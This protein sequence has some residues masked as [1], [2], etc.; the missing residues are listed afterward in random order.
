MNNTE[1]D[2]PKNNDTQ[3]NPP[4]LTDE[5]AE[6]YKKQLVDYFSKLNADNP[7]L[8]LNYL[9]NIYN[10]DIPSNERPKKLLMCPHEI[11]ITVIANVLEENE[12]GELIGTKDI[13]QKDYHIPVPP[14]HDYNE[15]M[16][17]FFSHLETC[18]ASSAKNATEKSEINDNE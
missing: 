8:L 6:Q 11:V 9:D 14:K 12:K 18:I 5:Q 16:R 15:Y 10:S 3:G 1:D 2:E 4:E 7:D 17:S 13:C